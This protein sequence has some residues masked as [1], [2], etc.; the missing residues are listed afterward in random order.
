MTTVSAP[1]GCSV[2]IA[3][4]RSHLREFYVADDPAAELWLR[5]YMIESD[6]H[7][8]HCGPIE[9]QNQTA[10]L[11]RLYRNGMTKLAASV[12]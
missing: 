4:R 8:V 6:P 7:T 9:E 10:L 2:E 12:H 3:S 11:S 5:H 1:N